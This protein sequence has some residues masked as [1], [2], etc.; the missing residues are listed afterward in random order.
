MAKLIG[1]YAAEWSPF[2]KARE[3]EH[4]VQTWKLWKPPPENFVKINC[5]G[6]F[7]ANMRS[8]GWGFTIR[9]QD[10]GVISAGYGKLEH[11]GEASMLKL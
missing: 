4:W 2:K 11:V 9:E 5:D 6:A 3:V 1:S 8:G 10:G 7:Y